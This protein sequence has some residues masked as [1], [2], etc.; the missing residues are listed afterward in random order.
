M[1][2]GR[3][4]D[5]SVSMFAASQPTRPTSCDVLVLDDDIVVLEMTAEILRDLGFVV[6]EACYPRDALA[7][8][9]RDDQPASS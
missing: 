8:F 5:A 9:C 7:R 2:I 1:T 3:N 6:V 4:Q